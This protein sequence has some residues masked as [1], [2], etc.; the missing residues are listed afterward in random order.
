MF[1][2]FK[3]RKFWFKNIFCSLL[4]FFSFLTITD[5]F[6]A[7]EYKDELGKIIPCFG[8]SCVDKELDEIAA[9]PQ[10]EIRNG[11]LPVVARFLIYGMGIVSF[12]IFF[13]AGI[14]LV[15]SEGEEERTKKAKNMI[16]YGI[17]GIAVTAASYAIV[18]GILGLDIGIFG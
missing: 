5:S 7:D 2:C 1:T 13:A 11:F 4:L 15:I 9:L 18:K 17:T 3:S 16:V 12:I 6:A 10:G 8:D 14:M